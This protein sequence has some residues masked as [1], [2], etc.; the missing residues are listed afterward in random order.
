M[1]IG[2]RQLIAQIP[3]GTTF[4]FNG[5]LI[6]PSKSVKNLGLYMDSYMSFETHINMMSKKV[7][8][9]QSFINRKAA[10]VFNKQTRI[11]IIKTLVLSIINYCSTIWGMAGKTQL[12][13]V[14]KLQNY[15]AKVAEGGIRKYD[16]V[17]PILNNLKWLNIEERVQY[18]VAVFVYKVLNNCMPPWLF[19]FDFLRNVR[20]TTTRQANNLVVARTNTNIGG[21]SF[22]IKGPNLWNRIPQE[23][24]GVHNINVFKK[25]LE[26]FILEKRITT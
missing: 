20:P 24:R 16:H 22:A 14:Q 3:E 7:F 5:E 8:G 9:T 26:I 10:T 12:S 6:K 2:S 25:K 15:A 1:F 18:D 21:Q 4:T 23:I 11:T 19:N 17:T 13:R